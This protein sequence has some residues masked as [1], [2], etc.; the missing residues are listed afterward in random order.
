MFS[1]A[2]EPEYIEYIDDGGNEPEQL[3]ILGETEDEFVEVK[4]EN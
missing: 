2:D 4:P 1:G 3:T